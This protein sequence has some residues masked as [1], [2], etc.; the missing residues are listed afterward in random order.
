[1]KKP[2]LHKDAAPRI[3]SQRHSRGVATGGADF[4]PNRQ[5]GRGGGQV[6]LLERP[7]RRVEGGWRRYRLADGA[8]PA[9]R[10]IGTLKFH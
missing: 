7:A 1:M 2:D 9:E 10:E 6:L 8:E 3:E 5:S 4:I